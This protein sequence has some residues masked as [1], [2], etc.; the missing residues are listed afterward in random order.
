VV[1]FANVATN[2]VV[3][4]FNQLPLGTPTAQLSAGTEDTPYS[5]NSNELLQGITDADDDVLTITALTA[6]YGTVSTNTTGGWTLTPT[7][8]YYG[9]VTLTY[10]IND[11]YGGQL[12]ATQTLNL[13]SVNDAPT[14]TLSIVGTAIQNQQLT[15]NNSLADADGLGTLSYQ[16][17][18]NSVALT[19]ATASTLNLTQANVGQTLS[20]EASYTDG[21]GT[22]ERISGTATVAVANEN[23]A[24]TGAVALSGTFAQGEVL[25]ASH[26]LSDLDGLGEV[27]YQWFAKGV[28]LASGAQFTLTQA[29]VNQS[30]TVRAT[31]TDG[32]GL[33]E[34]VSSG[35][36][37]AVVNRN[38]LPTGAVTLSTS[39]PSLWQTLTAS[40]TLADVDG[41]GVISYVWTRDGQLLGSGNRYTPEVTDLGKVLTV[42]AQYTDAF[43]TVEQLSTSTAQ[44]APLTPAF[45]VETNTTLIN[46]NGASA[47][48][49]VKLAAA[50]TREV[51]L[52]F[53][54]SDTSEGV[55]SGKLLS[56]TASNWFT[57][58]TL[59]ITGQNDY[60]LDSSQA[61]RVTAVVDSTDVNY[62]QL[63][64]QALTFTTAEDVTL[65]NK[66]LI[67]AGTVRDAPLKLYG[68]AIIDSRSI[69]PATGL[70]MSSGTRPINDVLQGLDGN[71]KL[72][73]KDLQDDLSGGLG[74]DVLSGENDEDHLYGEAGNDTLMG[75][76]DKDT[77][78]GG[79][80]DDVLNGGIDDLAADVLQGGAG[81]DTYYLG[82]GAVDSVNDMG[83]AT[84]VDT[85]I[86]PY[87]LT[88]Y[89][90]PKG[91]EQG[92]I[93]PGTSPSN[94]IGNRSDNLLT[95]NDGNNALT[96]S[97][98]ADMLV[99]GAGNDV[100][101]GGVDNDKVQG[102]FG[103]DTLTG[104]KGKD[105]FVLD[106]EISALPDKILDFK[107]VD[108]VISL[109]HILFSQLR[110][111]ALP[112]TQ[113]GFSDH[114][115]DKNDY[116]LYDAKQGTLLYDAD[117]S[118]AGIGLQ[119]AVIGKNLALTAADFMVV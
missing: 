45:I 1:S 65:T 95:G 44:V 35:A 11:G 39:T 23:D 91:I 88:R 75:G 62:R 42:T 18:A 51:T 117:A 29:E 47:L 119:I 103:T 78:Q 107:V 67:P 99:G 10:T 56:F 31:Y 30:L 3:Q 14:G 84:D 106:A 38:D 112:D 7:A 89:T 48:L 82:Y 94:L 17:F 83:L 71:D 50:P 12:N 36:T 104:G 79:T 70:F 69:D 43:G 9:T 111:G 4:F 49:S 54:S 101:N 37:S 25:T 114:A 96:G 40:N 115:L 15:L 46:E 72:Y 80:G 86:I 60:V 73:G 34:Q 13:T 81:N 33:I 27:S 87:Q 110:V 100:L 68:D 85:I 57:P 118:G 21:L 76:D 53:T 97:N 64:V 59:S 26:T 77:L 8:N 58:Q 41:L 16:W 24:P 32:F 102:G 113:L 5:L 90:L 2:D 116:L 108:D 22:A 61:F 52:T 6:D 63:S 28:L 55:I 74:D 92:A 98:G 109:D 105:Q 19:G 20:V 66:G 93:A